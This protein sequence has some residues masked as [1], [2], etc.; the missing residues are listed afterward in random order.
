VG[1]EEGNTLNNV[2]ELGF[3]IVTFPIIVMDKLPRLPAG[4]AVLDLETESIRERAEFPRVRMVGIGYRSRDNSYQC[5]KEGYSYVGNYI[6]IIDVSAQCPFILQD[7]LESL[8]CRFVV[9]LFGGGEKVRIY[10][11]HKSEFER[12]W[13]K[14]YKVENQYPNFLVRELIFEDYYS[15]LKYDII[16]GL[17]RKNMGYLVVSEEDFE[18]LSK[19][20]DVEASKLRELKK[21]LEGGG[22]VRRLEDVVEELEG[23]L[24]DR[25]YEAYSRRLKKCLE[26][27]KRWEHLWA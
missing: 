14:K 12:S 1:Y 23:Y 9:R 4:Y 3:I 5:S 18:K 2:F 21:E 17:Y 11:W 26:C 16:N 22:R 13:F 24:R 15:L 19:D 27:K 7:D 25:G 10:A 6:G 20:Q 8:F